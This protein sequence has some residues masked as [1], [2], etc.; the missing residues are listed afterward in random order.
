MGSLVAGVPMILA[1]RF[2]ASGMFDHMRRERATVFN[3]IGAMITMLFKQPARDDDADQ[4]ARLAIGG[5]APVQIWQAFERRFATRILEIYGLTE[6]ACFCLSSPPDDI[7]PGTIGTPVSWAEVRI[8]RDTGE[9]APPG[10]VGEICIR[11]RQPATLLLGYY[12]NEAATAEAMRGGWFHSGDRGRCDEDG[13][14]TFLDRI[15]DSIRRRGENISSYEIERIVNGHPAVAESAAVAVP[16]ELGEDEVMIV[17][18]TRDESLT[19][20]ELVRFCAPRMADFM[21]PRYVRFSPRLPK[22]A[23][24]RVQK[25]ELREAGVE[26]VW[27]RL[28]AVPQSTSR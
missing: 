2:S 16:S 10:E 26:G 1:P 3:Y 6:T 18:V 15:K 12:K 21:L 23:T 17:V 14:F 13:Y 5:A 11:S 19:P 24:E 7:R 22:T 8:E 25:F 27:D 4:P 9:P 20:E 28:T